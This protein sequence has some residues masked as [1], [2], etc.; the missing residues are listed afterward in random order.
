MIDYAKIFVSAGTG[1]DGTGSFR[2]IK[3]KR[4]GKADGGSG[5]NG[6][7]VYLEATEDLNTLEPYRFVKDY[8]AKDGQRG[9]SNLQKGARGE[10][11]VLRV[12]VGT[13]VKVESQ[14]VKSLSTLYFDF[15]LVEPGQQILVARGGQGGRGNA[16]LRDEYGRRPFGGEK[17]E[18][19]ESANLTLELKL[20]ADVGLIGLP[21]A[22]KS[23][24]LAALTA[25]KPQIADYPFTTLEPNL[26]VLYSS[27]FTVNS[28][29]KEKEFKDTVNSEPTT[30]NRSVKLV[31]ADIPGLIEGASQGKGLG[32][33]FLRHIERT[34][35]LLHLIDLSTDS[36]KLANYQIIRNELKNYSKGLIKKR[37]IVVFTKLDLVSKKLA[38]SIAKKFKNLKKE[39]VLINAFSKEGLNDLVKLLLK[40]RPK[41]S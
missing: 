25:A 2:H 7:H 41:R 6:G 40:S 17:G 24:L 35:M 16:Y 33:L 30:V 11:L 1:G 27:Q 28:S 34:R 31:L 12:P 38:E 13:L 39:V 26:G 37:E 4:R 21:N 32:D 8:F 18:I 3:G 14:S 29:Q 20:I 15:D 36:D 5:G 10:D 22:G 19:G 9:F 23:T